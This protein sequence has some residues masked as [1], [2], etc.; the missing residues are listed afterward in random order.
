MGQNSRAMMPRTSVMF[1]LQSCAPK[2][3]KLHNSIVKMQSTPV[4]NHGA[5]FELSSNKPPAS[6]LTEPLQI[7]Q[8]Q[9]NGPSF[10][11]SKGA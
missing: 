4:K 10:D 2:V 9:V 1:A 8:D 3:K 7:T 5:Y 6:L 11:R